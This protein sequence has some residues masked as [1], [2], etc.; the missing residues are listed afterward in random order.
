MLEPPT[1]A[2]EPFGPQ[3]DEG[4]KKTVADFEN[5]CI[6][7]VERGWKIMPKKG[8][9][10]IN[11]KGPRYVNLVDPRGNR[12]SVRVVDESLWEKLRVAEAKRSR[13]KSADHKHGKHSEAP[14]EPSPELGESA[15]ENGNL[16]ISEKPPLAA[17]CKSV[18]QESLSA[19]VPAA[20]ITITPIVETTQAAAEDSTIAEAIP[21]VEASVQLCCPPGIS[22]PASLEIETKAE[23]AG[24]S[25]GEL[26]N[27]ALSMPGLQKSILDLGFE[28]FL[29][30][31]QSETLSPAEILAKIREWNRESNNV[32]EFVHQWQEKTLQRLVVPATQEK[33]E[34]I[35]ELQA[36][37]KETEDKLA[38][39][40]K[41]LREM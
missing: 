14:S 10:P 3:E 25:P 1:P 30:A 29:T 8:T 20:E 33:D 11:K 36:T 35:S 39:T 40:L 32:L 12:K 27:F 28:T 23:I 17:T 7:L 34:L 4:N 6:S 21:Q 22:P 31:L 19:S 26:R 24:D 9:Y 38:E 15:V 41:W 13:K 5:V 16:Q 37:L 2:G 18:S